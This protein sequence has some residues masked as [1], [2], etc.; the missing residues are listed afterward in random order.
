MEILIH[1]GFFFENHDFYPTLQFSSGLIKGLGCIDVEGTE[2]PGGHWV[3]KDL[4]P[5][6][7]ADR[8]RVMEMSNSI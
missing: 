5:H 1:L 8:C 3:A 7:H 4:V 6:D 2:I